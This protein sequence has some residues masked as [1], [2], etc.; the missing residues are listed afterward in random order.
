MWLPLTLDR[1]YTADERERER[2]TERERG[3]IKWLIHVRTIWILKLMLIIKVTILLFKVSHNHAGQFIEF[4]FFIL[5]N[6]IPNK[7]NL[8]ISYKTCLQTIGPGGG[9]HARNPCFS[10]P[11]WTC[12][13]LCLKNTKLTQ[14]CIFSFP[15]A[16]DK[17]LHTLQKKK[18][19]YLKTWYINLNFFYWL[20]CTFLHA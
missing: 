18:T 20:I 13:M 1:N 8:Q 4:M 7:D 5:F 11:I 3:I 10:G 2:E 6:F 17:Y 19:N 14:Y 12:Y 15:W 16:A 9:G